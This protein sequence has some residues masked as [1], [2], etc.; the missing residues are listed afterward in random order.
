MSAGVENHRQSGRNGN[1][2]MKVV[3]EFLGHPQF[4]LN[5]WQLQTITKYPDPPASCC[6]SDFHFFPQL[7]VYF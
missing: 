5:L 6:L 2:E 4:Y 1:E 3:V 7:F